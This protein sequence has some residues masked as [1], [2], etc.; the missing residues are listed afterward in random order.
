MSTL[1]VLDGR[2]GEGGG[3]VLRSA[4]SLSLITGRPFRLEHVRA[5]RKPAGLKAQHLTCVLGA[6]TVGNA[7]VHGAE[8]GSSTVEF[9]P[10]DLS[11]TPRTLDVGTAGS[12]PLLLQCLFYPLAIAGGSQLTLRGGT[13]VTHSPTFDYLDR[14]WRPVLRRF[15]LNAR[16]HLEVAGFYP[17]GGG[18][19]RADIE[20]AERSEE[21]GEIAFGRAEVK[22]AEVLS[23]VGGLPLDI[24]RRQNDAAAEHLGRQRLRTASEV[25]EPRVKH[26]KGSA[27]LVWA[28]FA[29]GAAGESSLGERGVRAEAVGGDAAEKF[30]A[31]VE[32]GAS[33]D[34]HMGDQVLLPAALAAAGY[35]GRPRATDFTAMSITEHLT[36]HV[37]VLKSFLDVDVSI[38]DRFVRVQPG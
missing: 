22:L 13:H 10:G 33:L 36:T 3:Q 12:T 25:V 11:T 37:T 17:Q 15:G 24:A 9:H 30:L 19:I 20:P 31:F 38:E 1:V 23:T 14:V 32:S 7:R 16:L 4:L 26:S 34:V 6:A 35:L 28:A 5:R 8:L 21:D 2:E 18:T 27:V 29:D